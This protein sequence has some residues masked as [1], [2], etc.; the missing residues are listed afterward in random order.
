VDQPARTVWL[1]QG[2]VGA[3]VGE[4]VVGG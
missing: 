4:T 3:T 1:V 2:V